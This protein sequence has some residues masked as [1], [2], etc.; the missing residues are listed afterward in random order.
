[1]AEVKNETEVLVQVKDDID[2]MDKVKNFSCPKCNSGFATKQRLEYHMFHKKNKCDEK[3]KKEIVQCEYCNKI[4]SRSD[5][6]KRHLE[7]CFYFSE[8]QTKDDMIRNLLKKL[9]K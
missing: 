8:G 5:S 6:L 2:K 4:F 1:M 3:R 7:V 9:L